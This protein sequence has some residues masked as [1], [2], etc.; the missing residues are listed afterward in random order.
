MHSLQV[1]VIEKLSESM[2]PPFLG[3][4]TCNITN[5][6]CNYSAFS[7]FH[8]V[9]D[10][11]FT[12]AIY[13]M[14]GSWLDQGQD[15]RETLQ[16]PCL[17]VKLATV[18]IIF[19]GSD[20]EGHACLLPDHLEHLKVIEAE[21][22]EPAPKLL[23]LPEPE[24]VPVPGL[25]PAASPV[26]PPVVELE[27]AS[28][29]LAA[30]GREQ[31]PPLKAAPA[32]A[33][34]LEPTGR[35]ALLR[36]PVP[37]APVTSL[38]DPAP[39]PTCPWAMT[40]KDQLWEEKPNLLDHLPQLVA[41]Q[42][43]RMA[44]ELFKTLVPAHCLGS[45]WS[46]CDNRELEYLAPTVRDT[47]MHDNT[48]ANCI[49]VTCLG[50]LSMTAQ[51]RARVVE[52]WVWV[53]EESSQTWKKWC[54]EAC[55]QGAA[56]AG[57]VLNCQKWNEQFKLMEEIELLQEAANLYT[58]QPDKHFGAWFQAMEPLSEEESYSLSCQLEPRYHWARKI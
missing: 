4:I 41:E 45:I 12:N 50:D 22:K 28:P 53:A 31:G 29:E 9:L 57:D 37:S 34:A 16:F 19:G 24:P 49:L 51:D 42:L 20:L 35:C 7:T 44:A 5:F 40:T 30:P 1:A 32:P 6:V 13:L 8:Q 33:P 18:Y 27:P 52:L 17:T 54:R 3:R 48:M 25:E 43:T 23:S 2:V 26:S 36:L 21:Q 10:Q 56:P 14:W 11:L 47:V 58:V 55:E 15:C 46:E 38:P 39:E